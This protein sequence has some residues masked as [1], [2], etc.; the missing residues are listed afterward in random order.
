VLQAR[1]ELR[2]KK[3]GESDSTLTEA[4]PASR[5]SPKAQKGKMSPLLSMPPESM[6]VE[7][8]QR[9]AEVEAERIEQVFLKSKSLKGSCIKE[10]KDASLIMIRAVRALACRDEGEQLRQM[11]ADNKRLRGQLAAL[12]EEVAAL[13]R[14]FSERKVPNKGGHTKS[15]ESNKEVPLALAGEEEGLEGLT[16]HEFG[17]AMVQLQ[18]ELMTHLGGVISARFEG[19]EIDGRLLPAQVRRPPLSGTMSHHPPP[20][21]ESRSTDQQVTTGN[22]TATAALTTL[23]PPANE[24]KRGRKRTRKVINNK[25]VSSTP[26]STRAAEQVAGP[27]RE[28]QP[29]IEEQGWVTVSQKK[30][31][32]PSK[33]GDKRVKHVI[34]APKPPKTLAVVVTLK[35]DAIAEGATYGEALARAKAGINLG[36]LGIGPGKFRRSMTGACVM[37]LPRET[38]AAQADNLAARI[39]EVLGEAANVIRPIKM[40]DVRVS[41]LDDSVLAEELRRALASKAG[42][43]PEKIRVG[44]ITSGNRGMG[45]VVASCPI[46]S[47]PKLTKEGRLCVGWCSASVQA[48]EQRPLRCHRCLAKGHT[49]QMCPSNKDRS[50]LCYRCGKEGHVAAGCTALYKCALCSDKGLPAAH[51]MTGPQCKAPPV[52]GRLF[53][54]ATRYPVATATVQAVTPMDTNAQ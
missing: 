41:G 44:T 19:L 5:S 51:K 43:P 28:T 10:V 48:L 42:C 45:S 31:K 53:P 6:T 38:T 18:K 15:G 46:E 21:D 4:E 23:T 47:L 52:K 3:S 13:R 30:R 2:E 36:E 17:L 32:T 7:E 49:Q 29:L 35:P 1:R 25:A 50:G 27:S 8:I 12:G 39:G 34:K 40:A 33:K 24:P 16:R 11:A 26:V 9:R 20:V 22:P 14:A 54:A 37:E